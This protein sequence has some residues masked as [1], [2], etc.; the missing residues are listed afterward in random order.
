MFA[1]WS[2]VDWR[3]SERS[4]APMPK[5]DGGSHHFRG[6]ACMASSRC[7]SI[8]PGSIGHQLPSLPN[9]ARDLP[10]AAFCACGRPLLTPTRCSRQRS[11][12]S[13]NEADGR[14]TQQEPPL[15]TRCCRRRPECFALRYSSFDHLIGA[16]EHGGGE[17]VR[18][19]DARAICVMVPCDA[20]GAQNCV[21]GQAP[22]V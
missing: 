12:A 18:R 15:L 11:K 6:R 9:N 10:P 8:S 16:N 2:Q 14:R 19:G 22:R 21:G 7:A 3:S 17:R 4:V 13:A 5:A 20:T 1:R